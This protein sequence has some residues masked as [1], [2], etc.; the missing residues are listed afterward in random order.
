[1]EQKGT[2]QT[3]SITYQEW[4][5]LLIIYLDVNALG[6]ITLCSFVKVFSMCV[7][8]IKKVVISL[9]IKIHNYVCILN[10]PN[11]SKAL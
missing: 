6:A 2:K 8:I 10:S 5:A 7:C 1:M 11:T 9:D 3:R 4:G